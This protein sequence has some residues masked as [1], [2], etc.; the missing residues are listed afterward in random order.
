M[1]RWLLLNELSTSGIV[2]WHALMDISNHIGCK[3]TFNVPNSTLMKLTGLSK[4]GLM[5]AR[6]LLMERHFIRYE[7]GKR[8]Y[9]P[10]Y[11]II[12]LAH[13]VYLFGYQSGTQSLDKLLT[14]E[15]PIHKD[16]EKRRG[17]IGKREN[18]FS[19]YE[20]NMGSLLPKSRRS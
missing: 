2:L 8:G 20:Q 1:H 3:S 6:A 4:Q 19:V 11:E 17:G 13:S 5:N 15:F 9:A 18:V 16:K 10:I 7:R 14:E 12:S